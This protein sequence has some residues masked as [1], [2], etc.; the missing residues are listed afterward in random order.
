MCSGAL[1]CG[2]RVNASGGAR[3][4]RG[5]RLGQ[6]ILMRKLST[7]SHSTP[8]FSLHNTFAVSPPFHLLRVSEDKERWRLL[9]IGAV[10]GLMSCLEVES[11]VAAGSF[12][13]VLGGV[14]AMQ[15]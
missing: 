13:K 12:G 5:C 7:L 1:L 9:F 4:L 11:G 2:G 6:F 3:S 8:S 10:S 15:H 14:A